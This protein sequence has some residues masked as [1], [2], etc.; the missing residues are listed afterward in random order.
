MSLKYHDRPLV[1]KSRRKFDL[2]EMNTNTTKPR[3]DTSLHDWYRFIHSFIFYILFREHGGSTGPRI[4]SIN[5]N[6]HSHSRW[7]LD[8]E[9]IHTHEPN[10]PT[11]Y[12]ETVRY[13]WD[14]NL[15]R[16]CCKALTPLPLCLWWTHFYWFILNSK[17]CLWLTHTRVKETIMFTDPGEKW[18]VDCLKIKTHF[19]CFCL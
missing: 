7:H 3:T 19:L 8:W 13:Q 6:N 16:W 4:N 2:R 11:P 1:G 5:I 17:W 18:F 14:L 9:E 10:M 15:W 12:R